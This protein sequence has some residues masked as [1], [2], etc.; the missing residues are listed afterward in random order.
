MEYNYDWLASIVSFAGLAITSMV[1][2][3]IAFRIPA[4]KKTL[5]VNV[6]ENKRKWDQQGQKYHHRIKSSKQIGLTINL[7]FYVAILPFIATMAPQPIWKILLD[8]V[9][10]LMVYDLFYYVVH[11]FFFHGKGYFRRVHAVHHQARSRIS[12]VD[13]HLLHPMEIFIGIALYFLTISLLAVVGLGPFHVAA[14]IISTVIYVE[15]NQMNHCRIDLDGFPYRLINW[16]AMKHDAHHINM[17]KGNFAT[18]TLL[19]DKMFGTYEI[20]PMELE[21]AGS[22]KPQTGAA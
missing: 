17:H 18:I 9:L 19:Y 3:A 2:R 13:S 5:D 16:I 8:V 4:F 21:D 20:H 22:E 15:L 14:I 7:V 1:G 6:A 10:I 12:S 11:R